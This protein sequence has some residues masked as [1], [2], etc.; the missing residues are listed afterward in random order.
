M[1]GC[2]ARGDHRGGERPRRA[3]RR[4]RT[5][6]TRRIRTCGRYVRVSRGALE[7]RAGRSDFFK[8]SGFIGKRRRR[9]LTRRPVEPRGRQ[10]QARG[11]VGGAC[12]GG[13]RFI[14][15]YVDRG[16]VSTRVSNVRRGVPAL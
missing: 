12:G 3:R 7:S 6:H 16:D 4:V 9:G 5:Q 11:G 13:D 15:R 2:H 8:R 14:D 1:G 10:G